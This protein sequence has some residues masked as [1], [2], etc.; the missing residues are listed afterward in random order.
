[1]TDEITEPP[2]LPAVIEK[3]RARPALDP[4]DRRKA[5]IQERQMAR[6][7]RGEKPGFERYRT[8][9]KYYAPSYP[10]LP[11]PTGYLLTNPSYWQDIN[12]IVN[13]FSE[14]IASP[15]ITYE[16]GD[17]VK[18]AFSYL[19]AL[20]QNSGK[21]PS[22]WTWA[23]EDDP[24]MKSMGG[25][26]APP[27]ELQLRPP[28]QSQTDLLYNYIYPMGD[29]PV[30][31]VTAATQPL[32]EWQQWYETFTSSP[33]A[34]AALQ[35]LPVFVLST[36]AGGMVGGPVGALI[37]GGASIISMGMMQQGVQTGYFKQVFGETIGGGIEKAWGGFMRLNALPAE[38]VESAMGTGSY[39]EL[40]HLQRRL[41]GGA[42]LTGIVDA[43][44]IE[45]LKREK[46]TAPNTVEEW[47]ALWNAS[48]LSYESTSP[49]Q[50]IANLFPVV[51]MVTD[52]IK[53]GTDPTTI[54][55]LAGYGEV[56][57]LGQPDPVQL[58]DKYIGAAAM[59]YARN[60]ILKGVKSPNQIVGE[61]RGMYGVS[62]EF[63]DLVM[64]SILDPSWALIPGAA[65]GIVKQVG[66]ATG[67][68]Y[69]VAAVGQAQLTEGLIGTFRHFRIY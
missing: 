41:E 26:A 38:Y 31:A 1:M 27:E 62:G 12:S 58:E 57:V 10:A 48:R 66:L 42:D 3:K 23:G 39:L 33:Y 64:Q 2:V 9:S 15:D 6:V 18:G 21:D 37:A 67:N 53:G 60:E 4:G 30:S 20:P 46:F 45:Q 36:L 61:M 13:H 8:P 35:A 25:Y 5:V 51:E 19:K 63:G 17:M 43:R 50:K 29:L 28:S 54:P 24:I 56:L 34:Q 16:W 52:R 47:Q 44:I 14:V 49:F 65:K 11:A 22:E 7:E 55:K 40:A 32:P 69:L 68:K 59:N